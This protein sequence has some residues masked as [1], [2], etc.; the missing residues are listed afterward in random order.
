MSLLNWQLDRQHADKTNLIDWRW[1]KKRKD[2]RF[3]MTMDEIGRD[4]YA[5]WQY[6]GNIHIC[7]LILDT[8]FFFIFLCRQWTIVVDSLKFRVVSCQ[9]TIFIYFS[10]HRKFLFNRIALVIS[11]LWLVRCFSDLLPT[12]ASVANARLRLFVEMLILS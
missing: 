8:L 4:I 9:R 2:R 3:L 7:S 10:L 1:K 11:R 6:D 5:C 12:A